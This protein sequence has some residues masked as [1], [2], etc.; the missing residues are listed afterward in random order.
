MFETSDGKGEQSHLLA[1][2]LCA[3]DSRDLNEKEII[4]KKIKSRQNVSHFEYRFYYTNSQ[5][6]VFN[7]SKPEAED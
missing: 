6:I 1:H 3:V 5:K 4:T 7:V 2:D